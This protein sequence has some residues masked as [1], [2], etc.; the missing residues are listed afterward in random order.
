MKYKNFNI[1]KI[2]LLRFYSVVGSISPAITFVSEDKKHHCVDNDKG[3]LY[4]CMSPF[5]ISAKIKEKPPSKPGFNPMP[6]NQLAVGKSSMN[7]REK[8]NC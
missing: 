5:L 7:K 6:F 1:M 3:F 4:L 8:K 2:F